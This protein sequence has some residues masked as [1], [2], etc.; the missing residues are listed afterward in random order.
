MTS[1]IKVDTISENTSA[2]GVTIDG[3]TIKDGNIIGDVAL[4]GTT[5]TFTIGD[6]GAEDAA[7]IFD[8]NA[9]DFYIALDDSADDLIIG[10][11]A[12]VGT[13][14]MLSF[15]EAKAAA[16]TGAVTMASTLGVTG[17]ITTRG[18]TN[19]G[20]S[21]LEFGTININSNVTDGTIDFAQGLA[22]TNNTSNEGAWTQAGICATG[23]SGY[24]GNLIF[25][26]DGNDSRTNNSITERMRIT[27]DGKVG[28]GTASPAGQLDVQQSTTD[29]VGL[30]ILNT[31]NSATTTSS[32][33]RIGMTNSVGASYAVMKVQEGGSDDYP[34]II[35]GVQNAVTTTPTERMRIKDTGQVGIGET[36]PLGR[37][38]VKTADSSSG[39]HANA[40]EFVIE[41]SA[42][43]GMTIASGTTSH[44][45]I[46]F[47]DSGDELAGRIFYNHNTN[48]M[49]FGTSGVGTQ[50]SID[51]SGNQLPGNATS[52]GIYLGVTSATASNLLDDYEEGTWTPQLVST[53]SYSGQAYTTQ[54]GFYT[55]VGRAVTITCLVTYSNKGTLGGDFMKIIG[56]PFTPTASITYQVAATQAISHSISPS[57]ASPSVAVYGNNAF[58]YLF[59]QGDDALSQYETSQPDN[60]TQWRFCVTYQV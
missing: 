8:G 33:L 60:S 7:L 13:T 23:S 28:I 48:I 16:F 51:A 5:P 19:S 12:A 24:N 9:Q 3:L 49:S 18:T 52:Q 44:G 59:N 38:H 26:T 57:G 4:A 15:T 53:G 40:D 50:W 11:G 14:P 20:Y 43:S 1:T 32:Q 42:Y 31:N 56:L 6:A 35:F 37:L 41:G 2:N 47:A 25:G 17:K 22:F 58:A 46:A 10:L 39:A 30:S 27:S 45:T 54:Q 36:A 29:M 34:D 55:K 21:V